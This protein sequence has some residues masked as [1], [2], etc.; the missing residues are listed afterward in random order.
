M[1][2]ELTEKMKNNKV[3][4]Y[5]L[6]DEEWECLESADKWQWFNCVGVKWVDTDNCHRT[7]NQVHR[8]HPDWQPEPEIIR[9]EVRIA[10][11]GNSRHIVFNNGNIYGLHKAVNLPNFIAYEY[12][13]ETLSAFPRLYKCLAKNK[14]AEYPKYVL[15]AEETK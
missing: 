13:N 4:N 5:L 12:A 15:F 14:P 7:S 3:P 11:N 10:G 2:K 1:N 9:C 8:I 6:T